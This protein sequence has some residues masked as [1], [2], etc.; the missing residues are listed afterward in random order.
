MTINEYL[1]KPL[2]VGDKVAFIH[3]PLED[4]KSTVYMTYDRNT[5]YDWTKTEFQSG[6]E[7]HY[8]FNL[9]DEKKSEDYPMYLGKIVEVERNGVCICEQ[10]YDVEKRYRSDSCAPGLST[11]T[12]EHARIFLNWETVDMLMKKNLLMTVDELRKLR[13]DKRMSKEIRPSM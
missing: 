3:E 7:V 9:L 6:D 12:F 13:A 8:N 4:I 2:L 11:A 1:D 10:R 5:G